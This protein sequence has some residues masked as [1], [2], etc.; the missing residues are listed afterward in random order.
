MQAPFKS[1]ICNAI[2]KDVG[3][4]TQCRINLVGRNKKVANIHYLPKI[5][6]DDF[7][8][9]GQFYQR[10]NGWHPFLYKIKFNP[11]EFMIKPYNFLAKLAYSYIRNYTNFNHTCPYPANEPIKLSN[12]DI[13]VN[14]FLRRFPVQNGLYMVQLTIVR[15]KKVIL[16]INGTIEVFDYRNS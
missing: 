10:T 5:I 12:Y 13:E 1:L 7:E 6:I 15:K 8:A 3:E 16:S 2:D 9:E 4:F 11:C 14:E